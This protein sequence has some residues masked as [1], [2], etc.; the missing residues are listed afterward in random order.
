[1]EEKKYYEQV[2]LSKDLVKPVLVVYLLFVVGVDLPADCVALMVLEPS[3][4]S[5]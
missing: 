3:S 1:M 4:L 2:C 5:E